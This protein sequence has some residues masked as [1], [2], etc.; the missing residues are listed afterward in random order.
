ME[1]QRRINEELQENPALD[2]GKDP[3][4]LREEVEQKRSED[5]DGENYGE[6][7]Y[8]DGGTGQDDYNEDAPE[9]LYPSE[10]VTDDTYA[11]DETYENPWT[12]PSSITMTT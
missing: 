7:D 12:T 1:L 9:E 11:A 4:T 5:Y 3:E 8:P 2:E 6:E 10:T